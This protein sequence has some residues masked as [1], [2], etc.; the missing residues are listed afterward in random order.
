MKRI[1][2]AMLSTMMICGLFAGSVSAT[3][4][5]SPELD[6]TVDISKEVAGSL[7][8][9]AAE[10]EFGFELDVS[11]TTFKDDRWA[12]F[13]EEEGITYDAEREV[14]SFTLKAGESISLDLPFGDDYVLSEIGGWDNEKYVTT[15]I[16]GEVTRDFEFDVVASSVDIDV[17]NYYGEPDEPGIPGEDPQPGEPGGPSGDD[18]T[19]EMPGSPQTGYTVGILGLTAAAAASGAIAVVTGKKAKKG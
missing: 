10:L 3:G 18:P 8:A 14:L 15:A 9:S 5:I 6:R 12:K 16:N 13:A 7:A 11:K 17:V 4:V 19:G 1:F 2:A